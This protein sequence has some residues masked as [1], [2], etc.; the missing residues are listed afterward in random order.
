M[1]MDVYYKFPIACAL[2]ALLL[3]FEGTRMLQ[4]S[5]VTP[6]LAL[7]FFGVFFTATVFGERSRFWVV[8]SLLCVFVVLYRFLFRFWI[9]PAVLLSLL[10]LGMY[11]LRRK[12]VGTPFLD[13]LV[14]VVPGTL[15]FYG[16]RAAL[17]GAPFLFGVVA[18]E[19]LY[20][21]LLG[22]FVWF[23]TKQIYDYY[24]GRS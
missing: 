13:F 5:G 15:L 12:L 8:V 22:I 9:E 24:A 10:V 11:V 21:V 18:I 3:F 20:N 4:I 6:N 19:T 2:L 23:V 7:I 16:I 1:I 17:H 14:M